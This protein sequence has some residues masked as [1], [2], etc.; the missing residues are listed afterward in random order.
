MLQSLHAAVTTRP[1]TLL[2]AGLTS[3][4][5]L[6]GTAHATRISAGVAV[7]AE[8]FWH[9]S[10]VRNGA[11][12]AIAY[13]DFDYDDQLLKYMG[14]NG[15]PAKYDSIDVVF[16]TCYGGGFLDEVAALAFPHTFTS[17]SKWNESS[18]ADEQAPAPPLPFGVDNFPRAYR[19]GVDGPVKAMIR[20]FREAAFGV[21]AGNLKDPFAPPSAFG[22]VE[23]PQYSSPDPVVGG[24]N[25]RRSIGGL[26]QYAV[27]V[28]W[29]TGDGRHAINIARMR[30]ALI[31]NGVLAGNIIELW[32]VTQFPPAPP[33]AFGPWGGVLPSDIGG[34]AGFTAEAGADALEFDIAVSGAAFAIPPGNPGDKLLVFN[35]GHGGQAISI[36][37]LSI[38]IPIPPPPGGGG[39]AGGT[40]KGF[41]VPIGGHPQSPGE[42]WRNSVMNNGDTNLM[43]FT[44]DGPLPPGVM[45]EVNGA[46]FGDLAAYVV[47]SDAIPLEPYVDDPGQVHFQVEVPY[48]VLT[49]PGGGRCD[50][51]HADVRL[52][53]LPPEAPSPRL[54]AV[55][56]QGGGQETMA[57]IE[58]HDLV[59]SPCYADADGDRDVDFDD[60][61]LLMLN[62]G[63]SLASGDVNFDGAVD[64][65]DLELVLSYWGTTCD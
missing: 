46:G 51:A 38:Y 54:L 24:A 48:D 20:Y 2:L 55:L 43:Q 17:A 59:P 44:F 62:W 14:G 5:L 13:K 39:G 36:Q 61:N 4:T 21:R 32:G 29:N 6:A 31:N 1:S 53:G 58:G 41:T 9:S 28:G 7:E 11:G 18:Y 3:L 23:H 33:L 8:P 19:E 35:T 57:V 22:V 64:F 37:M 34:L 49:C 45:L 56:T 25:D 26:Q 15:M 27:L 60:L 52:I 42:R 40:G 10:Y 50:E 12:K 16:T 65:L 63:T 30:Q 47:T